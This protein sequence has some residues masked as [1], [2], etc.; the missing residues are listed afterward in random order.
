MQPYAEINNFTVLKMM[1]RRIL[2]RLR[3]IG[4]IESR[5]VLVVETGRGFT[6]NIR[7]QLAAFYRRT[8][9]GEGRL[10]WRSLGLLAGL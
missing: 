8:S 4:F 9:C 10:L 7:R 1:G 5:A 2:T 6:S 3:T